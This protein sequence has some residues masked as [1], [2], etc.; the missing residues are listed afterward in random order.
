MK[1]ILLIIITFLIFQMVILATAIDIGSPAINRDSYHNLTD[2]TNVVKA[3]PAN[4]TGK[5]TTVQIYLVLACTNVTIAIFSADGNNLTARD[6]VFLGNLTYGFIEREVNL[7]VEEGDYIGIHCDTG[8]IDDV[9]SGL[10]YW[11]KSGDQ[12]SCVDTAFDLQTNRTM[13]LYGIGAT[14][15]EEEANAIFMGMN[16]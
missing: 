13:S 12:T 14:E 11:W 15:E 3:N 5:I 16:F 4:G 8:R 2:V 10:G 6:S 1:K 9:W 7:D